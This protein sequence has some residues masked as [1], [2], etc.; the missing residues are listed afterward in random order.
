MSLSYCYCFQKNKLV[1]DNM[2]VDIST[3]HAKFSSLLS[4]LLTRYLVNVSAAEFFFLDNNLISN[5]N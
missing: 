5:V 2:T 4:G 1:T 3:S